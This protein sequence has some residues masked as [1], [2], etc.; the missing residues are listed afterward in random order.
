MRDP[1]VQRLAAQARPDVRHA[2]TVDAI[3]RELAQLWRSVGQ[4][5]EMPAVRASV[6][7]L[8]V[9]AEPQAVRRALGVL[10]ALPGR[11]TSRILVLI[12]T[13]G[14]RPGLSA[15]VAAHCDRIGGDGR[16]VC[17]EQVTLRFSGDEAE[18]VPGL[19]LPLLLPDLPLVL[20]LAGCA[21]AA[22]ETTAWLRGIA[23]RIVLDSA[24]CGQPAAPLGGVESLAADP[25]RTAAL[26]DL[27]WARIAP[28]RQAVAQVFDPIDLR[29]Y[30]GHVDGVTVFFRGRAGDRPAAQV[31]LLAGWV[32]A[33]L[34]WRPGSA[35]A[36]DALA[37]DL[38][39]VETA[40][41]ARLT[42]AADPACE[43]DD[44]QV[45]AVALTARVG[46][47]VAEFRVVRNADR[48]CATTTAT[49]NGTVRRQ[50]AVRLET[51]D[52][53]RLLVAELDR[54]GRA[55][56]YEAAVAFAAGLYRQIEDNIG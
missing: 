2:A 8:V 47:D 28:W 14:R 55:P 3:E 37:W 17:H 30:A 42:L 48:V 53:A 46:E 22:D 56:T 26:A 18:L 35:L 52:D 54:Q 39:R 5:G 21:S 9:F 4:P 51:A 11:H 10:A 29:R 1:D 33:C 15:S 25:D 41:R 7:N 27:N 13:D 34:G 12:P 50:R 49:V 45:G 23:D 40:G 32:M 16:R 19:V 38:R 20:W 43:A 6:L 31:W 44:G 24:V 36:P